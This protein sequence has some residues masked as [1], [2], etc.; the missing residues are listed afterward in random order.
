MPDQ[1][2]RVS[3]EQRR[4]LQQALAQPAYR[5]RFA[6]WAAAD[7]CV[8]EGWLEPVTFG[9]SASREFSSVVYHLTPEGL[10]RLAEEA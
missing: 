7:D 4:I 3:R 8:D 5:P 6:D 9:R 2:A 10:A 1:R